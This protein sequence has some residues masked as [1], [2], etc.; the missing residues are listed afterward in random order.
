MTVQT[1]YPHT[2]EA[3]RAVAGSDPMAREI[4]FDLTDL[5]SGSA[6]A[7]MTIQPKHVAPN[8]FLHATI[9]TLFADLTCG[10]G[11]AASLPDKSARFATLEIQTHHLGTALEGIL[12]CKA[13]GRHTGH[14]TQVWDAEVSIAETGKIITLFRCAQMVLENR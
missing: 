3:A 1:P 5:A 6:E 4:G 8:G 13:R 14:R 10:F 11:T 9:S 7:R 2:L 12:I